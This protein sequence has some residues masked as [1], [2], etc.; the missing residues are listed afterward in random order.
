MRSDVA[1]V[2]FGVLATAS[3]GGGASAKPPADDASTTGT[4]VDI[5]GWYQVTSDLEG[6]CGAT[7]TTPLAPDYLWV[8]RRMNT[9]V[10]R[11]CKT[12]MAE[13][14]CTGTLFYDFT[15]ATATGSKAAG[16]SAFYSAGCTLSYERAEATL[17]GAELHIQSLRNRITNDSAQT[18]CTLDAASLLSGPCTYEIDLVATRL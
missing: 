15:Q 1:F 5:S 11:V 8:E 17:S 18:A 3:C 7:V 14:S 2:L 13:A 12:P 10:V 4:V 9:F 16:G 6:P